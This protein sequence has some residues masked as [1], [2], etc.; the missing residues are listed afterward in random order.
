LECPLKAG[1]WVWAKQR[2]KGTYAGNFDFDE[3]DATR[4]TN[5]HPFACGRIEFRTAP[6]EPSVAAHWESPELRERS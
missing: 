5:G 4:F 3:M 2:F 6:E 1:I